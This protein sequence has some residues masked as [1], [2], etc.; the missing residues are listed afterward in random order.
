MISMLIVLLYSN[1]NNIK[2]NIKI[3]IN[4]RID[5]YTDEFTTLRHRGHVAFC[6]N[7]GSIQVG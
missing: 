1:K 6:S 3:N 7:Q 5:I 2:I 4:T